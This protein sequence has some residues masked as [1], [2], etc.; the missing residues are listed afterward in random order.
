MGRQF[1]QLKEI[2][3]QPIYDRFILTHSWPVPSLLAATRLASRFSLLLWFHCYANMKTKI[4]ILTLVIGLTAC[5]MAQ[6]S[7]P[8]GNNS[9]NQIIPSQNDNQMNRTG[10]STATN[11]TAAPANTNWSYGAGATNGNGMNP[12][13][14]GVNGNPYATYTNPN[15]IYVNPN[16]TN[17][18]PYA[19]YTNP[20]ATNNGSGSTNTGVGATNTAY[21]N[22]NWSNGSTNSSNTSTNR[23][24]WWKWR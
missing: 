16:S 10:P 7:P 4:S 15:S 12:M 21:A 8:T 23:H 18:N 20:Y 11:N 1:Q 13:T 24:H 9:Q 3:T 19:N 2:P 14:N 17:V 5:A 6:T 22:T